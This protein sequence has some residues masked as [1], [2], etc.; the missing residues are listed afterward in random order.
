MGEYNFKF[1]DFLV[2]TDN[3]SVFLKCLKMNEKLNEYCKVNWH[4]MDK[5]WLVSN[6]L[7]SEDP[8]I[9]YFSYH[10]ERQRLKH[11]KTLLCWKDVR[12]YEIK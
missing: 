7:G 11:L 8:I 12:Q 9:L 6:K 2:I 10:I 4:I 1:I 5:E 3:N